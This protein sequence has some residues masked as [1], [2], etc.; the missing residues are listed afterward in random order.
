MSKRTD[1]QTAET[2]E[3]SLSDKMH[4]GMISLMHD[5]FYGAFVNPYSLLTAAGLKQGQTVL[6][7]GCGPGFFTIPAAKIVEADGHLYTLDF[8]P[9]AVERVKQKVEESVLTNIDVIHADAAKTGLP[10]A[11][12]D[13]AFLF[14]VLHSLKNLDTV[15]LEMHRVLKEGGI[16]A[17]QK[18]SWS[19]AHLLKSFTE[20][21]LF[22]FDK[23]DSRI[24]RF[25]K[26]PGNRDRSHT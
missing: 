25:R 19:E 2:K 11:N 23:R 18:S 10:D 5:T 20:D 24:Y 17:V 12:V 1:I 3:V 7:V 6:E 16:V 15:L 8:N 4:L 14:G 13:V 22:R 21:G 9:A 26:E